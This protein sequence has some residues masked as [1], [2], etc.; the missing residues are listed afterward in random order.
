MQ[1][2]LGAMR[3]AIQDYQMI[4]D[5]DKIFVGLSGGKDSVLMLAALAQYQVFSPEKFTLEAIT[6]D[7]GLKDTS[8]TEMEA[9]SAYCQQLGV[10]HHIVKTEIA[11]V[12]FNIREEQNPC[13]LCA[14]MRRGSL[15]TEVNRLGGGKLALAHNADDVAETMLLS[16]LYEGRFSC[17]TPTAYM[18]KTSI[19]LIRP[20]VYLGE[21]E[22]ISAVKR[23]NLPLVKN[24]CPKN[25]HSK[26]E[27]AKNLI[28]DISKDIPFAKERILGAIFHPERNNLWQKPAPNNELPKVN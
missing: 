16:L 23:L 2:I 4:N 3:R 24:P 22:I 12:I 27:Y 19:T 13:S 18:S 15:N 1:K 17:F 9:L 8:A 20:M 26:R 10:P 11:D 28:K 14:K 6:I 25:H 7:M 21:D 5:G